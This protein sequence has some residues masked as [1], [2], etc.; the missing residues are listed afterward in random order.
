MS[1]LAE[2]YTMD[3][4]YL[5]KE[6][7][8]N[9]LF[10]SLIR[11]RSFKNLSIYQVVRCQRDRNSKEYAQTYYETL[12]QTLARPYTCNFIKIETLA[13][14]LSYEFCEILQNTFYRTPPDDC[15]YSWANLRMLFEM[16]L[17]WHFDSSDSP[18]CCLQKD[19]RIHS[20][21][22]ILVCF[23]LTL[24]RL[25]SRE[26]LVKFCID[27]ATITTI[28]QDEKNLQNFKIY[29]LWMLKKSLAHILLEINSFF[30]FLSNTLL[31]RFM[32]QSFYLALAFFPILYMF[33]PQWIFLD[34]WPKFGK[35]MYKYG[36][37]PDQHF[38]VF[39]VNAEV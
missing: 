32:Y 34:I 37:F 1:F 28:R 24:K 36:N 29:S 9:F 7:F 13:Q 6:N 4:F 15:F 21:D 23:L 12:N 19:T 17:L 18:A 33:G 27:T 10:D 25:S 14:V 35:K 39:G 30:I 16:K 2:N 26:K 8:K 22:V 20:Q 5:L 11:W 38:L 31:L 3:F